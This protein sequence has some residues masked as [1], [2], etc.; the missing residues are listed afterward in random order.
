MSSVIDSS[1]VIAAL[2]DTGPLAEWAEDTLVSG[3]LHAPEL[4]QGEVTNI[5]RRLERARKITT[6]EAQAAYDDLLQLHLELFPFE[7][8][9]NRIWQLRHNVTSYDAWYVAVAEALDL[10]F[11]TL[12]RR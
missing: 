9:A 10:P 6:F 2:I 5:L 4:I 8:F 3:S 1:V 11:A 12:D 7:P